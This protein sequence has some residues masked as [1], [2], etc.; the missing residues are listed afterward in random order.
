M[1]DKRVKVGLGR[2]FVFDLI[3]ATDT[4]EFGKQIRARL[5]RKYVDA[6]GG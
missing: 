2:I 6:V 1:D 4:R 3:D 5:R